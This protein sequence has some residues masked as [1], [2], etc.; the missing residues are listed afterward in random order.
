M[1]PKPSS[2]V[3]KPGPVGTSIQ[4][5]AD[6]LVTLIESERANAANASQARYNQLERHFI[7]FRENSMSLV[8]V[9]QARTH[10]T[11]RELIDTQALLAQY[12]QYVASTAGAV[13][14]RIEYAHAAHDQAR[15]GDVRRIEEQEK[16][17]SA[18]KRLDEL[19][20]VLRD[21]GIVF[22]VEDN[23]L[24]F[25]AGWAFGRLHEVLGQ[26]TQR[27]QQDHQH[28]AQLEQKVLASDEEK[29]QLVN[30]YELELQ[31][32]KLEISM[33]RDAAATV[34]SEPSPANTNSVLPQNAPAE[35]CGIPGEPS[36][37][38]NQGS[39][40]ISFPNEY[41]K[42]NS[43]KTI[44]IPTSPFIDLCSVQDRLS[45][46][47]KPYKSESYPLRSFSLVKMAFSAPPFCS[48][49]SPTNWSTGTPASFGCRRFDLIAIAL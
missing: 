24:R 20:A 49:N 25:E 1:D 29:I 45:K 15:Q 27:L 36:D 31:C 38:T 3:M 42:L 5:A 33:L 7:S 40:D 14:N 6:M 18:Q 43:D 44:T 19:Q 21:I 37:A 4:V 11:Q 32:L 35:V 23:S 39:S 28:I 46:P 48:M 9:E 13:Q 12:Q 41:H 34:S 26:L 10:Q 30:N 8:A 17:A 47:L 2:N 16:E 22:S